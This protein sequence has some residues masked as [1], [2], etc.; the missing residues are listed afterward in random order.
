M[1]ITASSGYA[2]RT[3]IVFVS[4]GRFCVSPRRSYSCSFLYFA[5]VNEIQAV[6]VPLSP[7]PS[8]LFFKVL[9]VPFTK[10]SVLAIGTRLQPMEKYVIKV[11]SGKMFRPAFTFIKR[12][13][14][15]GPMYGWIFIHSLDG[16]ASKVNTSFTVASC[17]TR[18]ATSETQTDGCIRS[19]KLVRKDSVTAFH[20]HCLW[21]SQ[22]L[23]SVY[24]SILD[25]LAAILCPVLKR[26]LTHLSWSWKTRRAL[27]KFESILCSCKAYLS[28][29]ITT[30]T[31][32]VQVAVS[33]F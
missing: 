3:V 6:S 29:R 16:W 7:P 24:F 5:H 32:S 21:Y 30:H 19:V 13:L 22:N 8:P 10:M 18:A 17:R 15:Q 14:V 20:I 27:I 33:P 26:R 9:S 4:R 11:R 25:E 28:P 1:E 2:R 12:F 23:I 31:F